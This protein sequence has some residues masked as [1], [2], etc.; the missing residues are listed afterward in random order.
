MAT[1]FA[2]C[3]HVCVCM[4]LYTW[5]CVY[6]KGDSIEHS[7]QDDEV[8]NG[9]EEVKQSLYTPVWTTTQNVT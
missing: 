9:P 2:E 6:V 3:V 5:V 4:Y 1:S 7:Q 8:D